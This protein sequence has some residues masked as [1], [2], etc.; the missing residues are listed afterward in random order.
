[1]LVLPFYL[2]YFYSVQGLVIVFEVMC[3]L[4][5]SEEERGSRIGRGGCCGQAES[6]EWPRDEAVAAGQLETVNQEFRVRLL[7]TQTSGGS[8]HCFNA[9]LPPHQGLSRTPKR[10]AL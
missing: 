6:L 8:G 4:K 2:R 9:L 3:C 10:P 5:N 7:M 1:M